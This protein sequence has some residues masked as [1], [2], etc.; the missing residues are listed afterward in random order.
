LATARPASARARWFRS[1]PFR[2]FSAAVAVAAAALAALAAPTPT[3]AAPEAT[4]HQVKARMAALDNRAERITEAYDAARE[5]LGTL[6]REARLSGRELHRSESHLA[7][8]RSSVV[9]AAIAA[10][11]NGGVNTYLF[12]G[13]TSAQSF[14]D[15]AVTL[16][17][18]SQNQ[19]AD[20]AGAAAAQHA[21]EVARSEYDAKVSAVRDALTRISAQKQQIEDLIAQA[22]QQIASLQAAQRAR[23][24]AQQAAEAARQTSM[25]ATYSGPASGQAAVAVRFAYAQLGKPYVYGA[26][27]PSSYDCSGLTMAAWGAAGVALPHNAA[28]QQ[29]SIPAVSLSAMQPGDLVFFGSP[30]YHVGIYIGGGNMIA[31]PHT[32]DVVKIEPISYMSPSGA[33]RP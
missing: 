25:R 19:A 16:N 28:M 18:I 10:Y 3:S 23:L 8:M 20:V 31:A 13:A 15:H 27:G 26:A 5:R 14:L 29:A 32:G 4:I 2:P 7:D 22:K 17:A 9:A 33:G 1:V 11:R 30:A 24:A 12:A 6:Q 21:V